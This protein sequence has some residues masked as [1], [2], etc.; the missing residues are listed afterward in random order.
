MT[1]VS[2]HGNEDRGGAR[3]CAI[4]PA[5]GLADAFAAAL[6]RY[7]AGE[8]E[9][10]QA[11][12]RP[13]LDSDPRH[14]PALMLSGIVAAQLL[15]LDAALETFERVLAI[16]PENPRAQFNQSNVLLLRG[17]WDR[18][19]P[20]YESRWRLAELAPAAQAAQAGP[21][22]L[23]WRGREPLA[24]KRILLRAE[25]GLGDT[26][27]FCRYAPLVAARGARVVLEVQRPLVS[28]LA[29]LPGIE[30]IVTQGGRLPDTDYECPLLSLPLAFG[31]TVATVPQPGAYLAGDPLKA[32]EWRARLG[33]SA[34]P[35]I[36]LFWRGAAAQAHHRRR[37]VPLQKLIECL[38][39]GFHYV[40][41]QKELEPDDARLLAAHGGI[42]DHGAD[43]H[44]FS[45]TA[46]LCECLD[47]VIS[48][49]S[50][51]AHLSAALGKA[52]WILLPYSPTWRW[53]L[54]REDTPWY[55]SATLLRQTRPDDWDAVCAGI[56]SRLPALEGRIA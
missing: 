23:P 30:R 34:A 12:L 43:Q 48:I 45:D 35:R 22:R 41:L 42:A 24:G 46:A 29:D 55:G 11:I 54:E 5:D 8:L 56:A 16:Q 51:V 2:T 36:G 13:L 6:A 40:S 53:L 25:Q 17:D 44:D 21:V 19:W 27:Q 9:G 26:L 32:A 52:T 15:E 38:P 28:L 14:V 3:A 50:S 4:G 33:A 39:R 7:E 37:S 10:T 1:P 31:T 18:G 49:D 20:L 47:L